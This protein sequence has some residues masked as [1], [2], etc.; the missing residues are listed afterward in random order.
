M[1]TGRRHEY[2]ALLREGHFAL[3]RLVRSLA[4]LRLRHNFP[5]DEK[6]Y[7][8]LRERRDHWAAASAN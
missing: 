1:M 2:E 8:A 7:E 3:E 4:V 5:L 6:S